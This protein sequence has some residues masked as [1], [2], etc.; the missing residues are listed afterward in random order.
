MT[1]TPDNP[2]KAPAGEPA[3]TP[4]TPAATP[5]TPEATAATPVAPPSEPEPAP[6][7]PAAPAPAV[8]PAA[9][10]VSLPSTAVLGGYLML[11]SGSIVI[12]ELLLTRLFALLLVIHLANLALALA[13]LGI[14]FGATAFHLFPGLVSRERLASRLGWIAALQGLS[15]GAAVAIALR[16]EFTKQWD[17]SAANIGQWNMRWTELINEDTLLATLPILMLP[18]FFGGLGFSAIFKLARDR[19]GGLYAAD[20]WGGAV[21]SALFIPLLRILAGPDTVF[22]AVLA[23]AIAGVLVF[24]TARRRGPQFA[25]VALALVAV[26]GIVA[27]ASG[28]E[29]LKVVH[30]AGYPESN[31]T[32]REWTPVARLSVHKVPNGMR[33]SIVLD[34]SSGSEIVRTQGRLN[35]MA[36]AA[37]R[38]IPF[39]LVNKR[40]P[41]AIIAASAGNDVAVAQHYGFEDITAIDIAGRIFGIVREQYGDL[42]FNPYVGKHVREVDA[43]GR[44]GIMHSHRKYGVI[45]MRWANLN[46]A[47]GI[48]SNA[49]SP[50]LLETQQAFETYLRHLRPDGVI[51][52]SKGPRSTELMSSAAAALRRF[53]VRRPHRAMALIAGSEGHTLIIR[54]HE[55]TKAE[56]DQLRQLV[57][58][59]GGTIKID[60]GRARPAKAQLKTQVIT[61]DRPYRDTPENMLGGLRRVFGGKFGSV[62]SRI[63]M[64]L[65]IQALALLAAGI[66]FVG[67]PL[68]WRGRRELRGMS[69]RAGPL[70][71]ASAIGYAYLAIE[72][73]LI[74]DLIL[75]VGHPTYAITL[76]I[77]VMLLGSGFGSTRAGRVPVERLER[78]LRIALG[79]AM[80]LALLQARV[81]PG[82]Y[83]EFLLGSPLAVRLVVVGVSLLPLGYFMGMSFPLALRILPPAG[84][85]MVP[86]MWAL[87]GWMSVVATMASVFVSRQ[88]GFSA[89]L[90]VAIAFYG[91]AF[92]LVGRLGKVG[93]RQAPAEPQTPAPAAQAVA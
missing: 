82:L 54:P 50:A 67:V 41:V 56:T 61:D 46:N 55:F 39:R 3:A 76:V 78:S 18:F 33:H 6:A 28:H 29:I 68:L 45:Q 24:W 23:C 20:L 42:P 53:G 37:D 83:A 70:A 14:G 90:Y 26:A 32:Y 22:A 93:L 84:G 48:I 69:G 75:F 86:W 74:H 47:A 5:E 17:D 12:F 65:W 7:T 57:R 60:P 52:F 91:I 25:M 87:N 34:T 9:P 8:P 44:A 31:V 64:M 16:V 35:A 4:E 73:V 36:R 11:L 85:E 27:S 62:L 58:S 1:E 2:D 72:T 79:A 80:V 77:L 49:W 88:L 89:A 30:T 43:D 40:A 71:Y 19:I 81:L 21:G 15:M 51:A 13:L 92:L 38:A 10:E 59:M 63:N 66:L